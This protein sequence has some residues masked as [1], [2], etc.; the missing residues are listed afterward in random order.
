MICLLL[1]SNNNYFK[2]HFHL[3]FCYKC[4]LFFFQVAISLVEIQDHL[5]VL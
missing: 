2:V 4:F 1:V 5:E 3:N